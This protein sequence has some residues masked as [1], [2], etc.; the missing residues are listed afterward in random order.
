MSTHV[1]TGANGFIAAHLIAAL[2]DRGERVIGLARA[3][4]E[5]TR[6]RLADARDCLGLAAGPEPSL[7]PFSLADSGLGLADPAAV[8]AEPCVF[9]HTAALISYFP[10][11]RAELFR[12]NTTGAAHAMAAFQRHA[13]PGSRFV[14]LSTA[15]QCGSDTRDVPEDWPAT[16]EPAAYR[17]DYEY[18]KR[19]AEHALGRS[20]IVARLA[21]MCGHSGT[22]R[23][24]TDLGLYDFLRTVGF[25]A[26]RDPGRR[27]RIPC[28]PKANLHLSPIDR[29]V[30]RLMRIADHPD[31]A[32]FHVV[33]AAP[34]SIGALLETINKHLPIELVAV[35]PEEIADRPYTRF[36]AV[37]NMRGKYL[38]SYMAHHYEFPRGNLDRLIGPEPPDVDAAV[39]DRLVSWYVRHGLPRP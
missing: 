32:V 20:A 27:A 35:D 14:Y 5:T 38:T 10:R 22:G 37:L 39:L 9:W 3:A 6:R 17:N 26:R 12:V 36:E 13:R 18:S 29:C 1:V 11:R 8:F 28:H 16:R 19:A 23:T 30:P 2:I 31:P 21:S 24:L 25:F 7:L 34:V 33:D 15:Y 4:P